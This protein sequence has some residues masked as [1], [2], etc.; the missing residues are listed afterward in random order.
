VNDASLLGFGLT[1]AAFQKRL[2]RTRTKDLAVEA[3]EVDSVMVSENG[4]DE[5][6]T[7]ILGK[8]FLSIVR[9]QIFPIKKL[10]TIVGRIE[11]NSGL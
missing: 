5:P 7:G 10:I 8:P 2:S 11:R 3:H 1:Q 6:S 4:K 9:S